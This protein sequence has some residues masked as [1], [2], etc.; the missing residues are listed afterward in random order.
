MKRLICLLVA[1]LLFHSDKCNDNIKYYCCITFQDG[2]AYE[3]YFYP[4]YLELV[5]RDFVT[6]SN[7]ESVFFTRDLCVI[8]Q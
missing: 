4:M 2:T 8:D 3:E 6:D 1:L 5:I 7:I